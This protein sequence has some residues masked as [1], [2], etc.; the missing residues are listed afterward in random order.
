MAI[1]GVA[2]SDPGQFNAGTSQVSQSKETGSEAERRNESKTP[3]ISGRWTEWRRKL[4]N[5]T[6][7]WFSVCMGTGIV[8]ELLFLMPYRAPGQ[9]TA[10]VVF[11]IA[12]LVLFTSFTLATICRYFMFP[13]VPVLLLQHPSESLYLGTVPMAWATIVN[14]AVYTGAHYGTGVV[15][16]AW[17]G[18]WA[19]VLMSVVTCFLVTYLMISRH[20]HESMETTS[21]LWL[22]PIVS[23]PVASTSAAIIIPHLSNYHAYVTLLV[24]YALW[25]FGV[26]LASMILMLYLQR[27][28]FHHLPPKQLIVSIWLPIGYLGQGV[29]SIIGLGQQA[30]ILFP[31]LAAEREG[32][33]IL[34]NGGNEFYFGSILMAILLWGFAMWVRPFPAHVLS[35]TL[36]P[37]VV[38]NCHIRRLGSPEDG[39]RILQRRASL[40]SVI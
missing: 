22:L 20:E 40:Y 18:W 25:G 31:K 16:V 12:N 10:G 11:F 19:D 29:N 7:S 6:L 14:M 17:A 21:S 38:A 2:S 33:F 28:I 13:K 36:T 39:V 35:P 4:Q 30:Q 15:S 24:G 5:F 9:R 3:E 8:S 34:A 32:D 27:L 37:S 1:S 26:L 23:A